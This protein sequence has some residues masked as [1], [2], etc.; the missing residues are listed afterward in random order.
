MLATRLCHEEVTEIIIGVVVPPLAALARKVKVATPK[1]QAG[2]V[3]ESLP[4]LKS[5]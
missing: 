5:I 1:L 4:A 2:E 3:P